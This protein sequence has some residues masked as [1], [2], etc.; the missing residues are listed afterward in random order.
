MPLDGLANYSLNTPSSE[1]VPHVQPLRNARQTIF[2]LVMIL[3]EC[4][5]LSSYTQL[6]AG[7]VL[8]MARSLGFTYEAL[9]DSYSLC[10]QRS[11]DKRIEVIL[12]L[13]ASLLLVLDRWVRGVDGAQSRAVSPLLAL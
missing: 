1:L 3:E 7:W 5:E 13:M 9:A 10:M 4:E 11:S 8:D 6:P 12:R 2:P